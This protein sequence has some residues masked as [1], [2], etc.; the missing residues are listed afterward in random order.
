M[1]PHLADGC[2]EHED[3]RDRLQR[4]KSVK[5]THRSTLN[6]RKGFHFLGSVFFNHRNSTAFR[7]PCMRV[8]IN[9][10][11][12]PMHMVTH[13]GRTNVNAGDANRTISPYAIAARVLEASSSC[14]RALT[15]FLAR[16]GV[17]DDMLKK[18]LIQN[19]EDRMLQTLQQHVQSVSTTSTRKTVE[20]SCT[21]NATT[22]GKYVFAVI[23]DV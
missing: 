9:C 2:W 21:N 5:H 17:F 14:F 1:R 6:G 16:W 20:N 3:L 22:I 13:P 19:L 23:S 7:K 15:V 8:T 4:W 10:L 12:L 18:T 11:Q